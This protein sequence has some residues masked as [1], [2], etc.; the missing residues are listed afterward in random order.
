ML[1]EDSGKRVVPPFQAP[2]LA[3]KLDDLAKDLDSATKKSVINV[4]SVAGM[5]TTLLSV[6]YV[7]WCLRGG[8][9]AMRLLGSIDVDVV[10]KIDAGTR[11]L[12]AS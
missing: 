5:S 3:K 10:A 1:A 11:S 9:G 2:E 4:G 8:Y 12:A 6:G 7:I